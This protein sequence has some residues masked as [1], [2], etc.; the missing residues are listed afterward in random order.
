MIY[1]IPVGFVILGA[2]LFIV[3]KFAEA[4]FGHWSDD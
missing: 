3:G 4:D 1:L 2:C